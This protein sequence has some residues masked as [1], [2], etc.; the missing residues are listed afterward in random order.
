MFYDRPTFNFEKKSPF[1]EQQIGPQQNDIVARERAIWTDAKKNDRSND[2]GILS[3]LSLAT[4]PFGDK[5][6]ALG[7]VFSKRDVDQIGLMN[8]GYNLFLSG[9]GTVAKRGNDALHVPINKIA[10]KIASFGFTPKQFEIWR[11]KSEG[12]LNKN[13]WKHLT[14][15]PTTSNNGEATLYR[16]D[17]LKRL[18]DNPK[19]R[20]R[21]EESLSGRWYTDDPRV[22]INYGNNTAKTLSLF[23]EPTVTTTIKTPIDNVVFTRHHAGGRSAKGEY[24]VKD[25]SLVRRV[26]GIYSNPH[27]ATK[28]PASLEK[29]GVPIAEIEA[30]QKAD[31][32]FIGKPNIFEHQNNMQAMTGG[33]RIDPMGI[34]RL[35]AL[36]KKLK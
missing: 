25:P 14:T 12:A 10:K 5:R 36:L 26:S 21:G 28:D 9:G 19:A 8:S 32:S 13:P 11:N 15:K 2:L 16:M 1:D 27:Y 23:K 4:G 35:R 3:K 34:I 7:R 33:G 18:S 22:A 31:N 29:M 6:E 30:A 17:V 24:L 20:V